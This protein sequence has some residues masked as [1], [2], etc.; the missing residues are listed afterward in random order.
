MT[1]ISR[2]KSYVKELL[3]LALMLVCC[4]LIARVNAVTPP[5]T[6]P[7]AWTVLLP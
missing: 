4:A 7:S 3:L 1:T 5:A 6:P 2:K